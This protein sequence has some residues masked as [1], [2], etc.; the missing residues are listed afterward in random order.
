[1]WLRYLRTRLARRLVRAERS[2]SRSSSRRRARRPKPRGRGAGG[3]R[4]HRLALARGPLPLADHGRSLR[5]RPFPLRGLRARRSSYPA[6]A[7]IFR[8][9]DS[10]DAI[11]VI[12]RGPRPHLAP[13]LRAARRPSRS[14]RPARSSARWRCSIRGSGRSADA[15][16]ARG[17][18]RC[19]SSP[20]AR[21]EALESADPEGCAELSAL[22][23]RLAARRAV[24][25]AE[26]L[27]S[28]R[29]LAGPG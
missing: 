19:S 6:E 24:E 1:M 10:G 8:E 27:A 17:G 7:V 21:F 22:L 25:T 16:R 20:A 15:R 2:L 4:R 13:D 28:W 12:A 14:S 26:R 9:G 5:V 11:Y 23:C 3:R 18:R 29:V